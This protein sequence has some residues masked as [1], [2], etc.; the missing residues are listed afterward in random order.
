MLWN[1]YGE[2]ENISLMS[3]HSG[4]VM[5][6]HFSPDGSN[7]FTASTDHTLGLWDVVTGQRIKKFKGHTTFVNSVQGTLLL[8]NYRLVLNNLL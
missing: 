2:C 5:E 8:N 1:V 4:A 7:L 3:G 6:M